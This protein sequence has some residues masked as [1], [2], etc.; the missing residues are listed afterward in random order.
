MRSLT[1]LSSLLIF[2]TSVTHADELFDLRRAVE[3]DNARAVHALIQSG[4]VTVNTRLL[5]PGMNPPGMP[6][7]GLA[8]REGSVNVAD[9]LIRAKADLDLKN[10]YGETPLMLAALFNDQ[11]TGDGDPTVQYTKHEK[12]ARQLMQSGADLQNA[13]SPGDYDALTYSTFYS[14]IRITRAL[15]D[16]GA[17]VNSFAVDRKSRVPT[18]LMIAAMNGDRASVQLLLDRGADK[19]IQDGWGHDAAYMAKKNDHLDLLPLV[20]CPN[21]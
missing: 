17:P 9:Y 7:L 16:R 20:E 12:I 4:K 19:C 15:L 1:A 10:T 2:L 21:P 6:I 8:A 11:G 18:A 5:A 13:G 14:H 3:T